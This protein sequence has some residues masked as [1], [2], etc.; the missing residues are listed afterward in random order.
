MNNEHAEGEGAATSMLLQHPD[1]NWQMTTNDT[2]GILYALQ[3]GA[4][5]QRECNCFRNE[6]LVEF[7]YRSNGRGKIKKG[8][9]SEYWDVNRMLK[10]IENHPSLSTSTP[11]YDLV[12]VYLT[13][14]TDYTNRFFGKTHSHFLQ[15]WLRHC[16]YIGQLTTQHPT[17][18]ISVN[19]AAVRRLIHCVYLKGKKAPC[20]IT[21][22]EMRELTISQDIRKQQPTESV[23]YEIIKRIQGTFQYMMSYIAS[24]YK[25]TDWTRHGFHRDHKKNLVPTLIPEPTSHTVVYGDILSE[26]SYANFQLYEVSNS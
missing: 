8:Q 4:S 16:D 5:R 18:K 22:S 10:A 12:V 2:D 9:I 14:G 3:L 1:K 13:A 7:T 25:V 19:M 26:H 6:F 21:F 23:I 20:S 15:T 11:I 24:N 17:T